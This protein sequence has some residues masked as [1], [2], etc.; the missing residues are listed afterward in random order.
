MPICE[1]GRSNQN[2][3]GNGAS[4]LHKSSSFI[5]LAR[6]LTSPR[7]YIYIYIYIYI[8]YFNSLIACHRWTNRDRSDSP[9]WSRILWMRTQSTSPR[10]MKRGNQREPPRFARAVSVFFRK[11]PTPSLRYV[12]ARSIPQWVRRARCADSA[13]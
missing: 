7:A 5:Y 11:L 2:A 1:R 4:R 6:K 9:R 13:I 12:N 8:Y 3:T 10:R